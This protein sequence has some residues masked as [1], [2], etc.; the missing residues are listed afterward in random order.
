MM[1]VMDGLEVLRHAKADASLARIPVILVTS[2]EQDA[3]ILDAVK[4]GAADYL[5]KPFTKSELLSRVARIIAEQ[6][7]A[8]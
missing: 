8:A 4:L 5:V 1:P 7:R 6:R 2:R 3:D